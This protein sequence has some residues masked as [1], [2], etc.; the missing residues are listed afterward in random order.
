MSLLATTAVAQQAVSVPSGQDVSL[1]EVLVDD[2][3]GQTWVRFRFVAPAI[4][5]DGGSVA[6]DVAAEDMAHLCRDL[7]IP[8]MSEF[9]LASTHIVISMSDRDVPFGEANPQ[10]TQ[11][12][13]AYR[14]EDA[15]CIWEAY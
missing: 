9:A 5:R 15:D 10:A 14:L 1:N 4:A 7:V 8:Y 2:A 12:F 13:E 3:T 11:Y 6:Y